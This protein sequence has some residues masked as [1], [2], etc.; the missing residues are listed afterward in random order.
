MVRAF[1]VAADNNPHGEHDFGAC[2][3]AGDGL[4]WNCSL[5]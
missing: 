4:F 5:Q 1:D 2:E 3:L